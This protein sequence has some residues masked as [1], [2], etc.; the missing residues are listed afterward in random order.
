M[1]SPQL[2]NRNQNN[3]LLMTARS[4]NTSSSSENS[5]IRKLNLA[6]SKNLTKIYKQIYAEM[7][8]KAER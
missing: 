1:H 5:I 7:T 3:D 8:N 2:N 4:S 6:K